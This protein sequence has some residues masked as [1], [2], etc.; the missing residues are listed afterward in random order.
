MGGLVA[1][2]LEKLKL[3][4]PQPEKTKTSEENNYFSLFATQLHGF[5][6]EKINPLFHKIEME[7]K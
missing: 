1:G 7:F 5:C 6:L 3:R 2:W 4:P